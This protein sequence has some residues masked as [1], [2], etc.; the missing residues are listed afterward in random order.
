MSTK[1]M[2][3]AGAAHAELRRGVQQLCDAVGVTM[4]PKGHNVILQ[5]SW[6]GPTV[7]KDGVTVAKEIDLPEPFQNM[8]AKMVQQVAKKTADVAGDGTTAATVLAGRIFEGGLKHIAA[9]ANAVAVQRGINAAANAAANAI[10]EMATPCK[11]KADL[12]KVATVSANHDA[13]IGRIIAEAIDKVGHDG[14]A[15]IE[16]SKTAETT[17]EYVER[18]SFDKGFLSPYF[19]TDPKKAQCVLENPLIL[20]YEK[21]LANLPDLLPLLN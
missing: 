15:E 9:G 21:K 17:L 10:A 5:K 4:G 19:M 11:G 18:M 7:T 12:Q 13:E 6:G 20:L 2:K 16:E 1:Q 3:F 8:G 14:V